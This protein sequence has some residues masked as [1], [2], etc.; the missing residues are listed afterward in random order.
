MR[1]PL[2]E[3]PFFKIEHRFLSIRNVFGE[4]IVEVI[5]S[6]SVEYRS[7]VSQAPQ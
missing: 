2:L 5:I 4:K 6:Q 7:S 3:G 1:E